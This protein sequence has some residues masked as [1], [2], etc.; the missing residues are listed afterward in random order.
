MT[1]NLADMMKAFREYIKG[2]KPKYR[3]MHDRTLGFPTKA[4]P[5]PAAVEVLLYEG[6]LRSMY[7]ASHVTTPSRLKSTAV[8]STS[9]Q[10]AHATSV[11]PSAHCR[12]HIIEWEIQSG[13]RRMKCFLTRSMYLGKGY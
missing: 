1:V 13:A 5:S 2:F 12:C 6:Y 4:V 10:R 7:A 8:R 3:V 9:R 11:H